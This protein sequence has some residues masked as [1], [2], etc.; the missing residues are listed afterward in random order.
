MEY[1][2]LFELYLEPEHKTIW[3]KDERGMCN[4]EHIDGLI[5]YPDSESARNDVRRAIAWLLSSVF[6]GKAVCREW[7][8]NVTYMLTVDDG[9]PIK[10]RVHVPAICR[11]RAMSPTEYEQTWG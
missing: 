5:R 10:V 6:K 3:F 4:G 1:G 9:K 8:P 11:S 2:I 7:V